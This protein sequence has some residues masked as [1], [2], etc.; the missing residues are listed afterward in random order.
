MEL[1]VLEE[2]P[3]RVTFEV[4]GSNHTLCNPLKVELY[5]NKHVK[6]ATYSVMHPL[7][8]VPRM[9]VE[10]DGEVKPRKLLADAAAKLAEAAGKLKK[11]FKK[12]K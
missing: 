7:V 3:K 4:K 11:E 1:N 10:T 2:T 6:V 5:E 12:V 8:P 9:I